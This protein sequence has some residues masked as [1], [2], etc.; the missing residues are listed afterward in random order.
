MQSDTIAQQ[1]PTSNGVTLSGNVASGE[2]TL[3]KSG[4]KCECLITNLKMK[5]SVT[6][7]TAVCTLPVTAY[8]NAA[9][10]G[11]G[12]DLTGKTVAFWIGAN[13]NQLYISGI[14]NP[15][16]SNIYGSI[17]FLSTT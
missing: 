11:I 14:N 2:L 9:Y 3:V 5:A 13:S 15:S 4:H 10:R 17:C 6:G 1:N 7:D 8:G 16:T 12:I